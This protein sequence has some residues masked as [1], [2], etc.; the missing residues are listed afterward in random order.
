MKTLILIA[1]GFAIGGVSFGQSRTAGGQRLNPIGQGRLPPGQGN[2]LNPGIPMSG[3]PPAPGRSRGNLAV[4][5]GGIVYVP[6]AVP[7]DPYAYG[8]GYGYGNPYYDPN[9]APPTV[10][11]NPDYQSDIVHPVLNDYTN[12]TLPQ[13]GPAYDL[14]PQPSNVQRL[15]QG[16]PQTSGGQN[17]SQTSALRDDQPT[18]FLIAMK[19][20]TI[21]P[22]IAYWVDKDTFNYV[23]VESFVKRVPLD[24]VDRDLSRQLNNE[25]NLEFRLPG[26]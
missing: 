11:V 15:D 19:D 12:V 8:G 6:Y 2:L 26:R 9:A 3:P 4:R 22:V 10:V 25:R 5:G 21:Y 18:I 17:T 1:A 24:Q 13:P 14:S 20:H 16:S 23:T 7:I